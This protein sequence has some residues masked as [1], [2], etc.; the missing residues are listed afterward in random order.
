MKRILVV[1]MLSGCG[2]PG[3]DAGA[4]PAQVQETAPTLTQPQVSGSR[5]KAIW[6]V[7]ADGSKLAS[8]QFFDTQL[9]VRCA[10][11]GT[12]VISCRPTEQAFAAGYF[13]DAACTIPGTQAAPGIRFLLG[14]QVWTAV[15]L[16]GPTYYADGSACHMQSQQPGQQAFQ[17]GNVVDV[18]TF[19]EQAE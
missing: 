19:T 17:I 3:V 4:G 5:L 13:A 15:P 10:P 18:V 11:S 16:N 1:L 7:G 8:G 6:K 14:A 12:D 9:Q 2:M